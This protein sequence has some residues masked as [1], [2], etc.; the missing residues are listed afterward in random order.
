M[1]EAFAKFRVGAR[2][3][4]AAHASYIT[5]TSALDP[6]S[7]RYRSG[8][9]EL[10]D[11]EI[12]AAAAIDQDLNDGLDSAGPR[13][14]IDPVW[15]W[16]APSHLTGDHFGIEEERSSDLLKRLAQDDLTNHQQITAGVTS[17][18]SHRRLADKVS[19]LRAYFGSK[20]RFEKLK[21]GRTHYRVILSF[22][23][24]ATNSQIRDLTNQFLKDTF[25][26]A[27]AFGAIHRDTEHPHVHLYVHARQIDG[28]KIYL[29]KNEY[30][31][32][33]EN[34][35]RIYSEFAGDRSVFIQHL[36]KKEE[37]KQWKVAAAEAY[38]KGEL[39]PPKPERDSDRRER[40][41]EQK[42]SAQRSHARDQ[43]QQLKPRPEAKPVMRP[44][45]E[46]ETSRLLAKE[47]VARAELAHLIRIDTPASQI[48]WAA[49]SAHQFSVA[50][51][52]TLEARKAIGKQRFPQTVYTKDEWKQLKE[53]AA[54]R[55]LAV[56]DDP[57]AA[58]LQ[59]TRILAGAEMRDAQAR[60]DAFETRRHF[61][62]FPVEGL[63]K[64]SLR[65]VE[66]KIKAHTDDKFRLYNFLRP[67]KR[68]SIQL[69]IEFLQE[70]KKDIQKQ[71]AEAER[72]ARGNLASA[73][74]TFETVTT[75]VE[76][77]EKARAEQQNGMP[78]P[79]FEKAELSRMLQIATRNTDAK[80]LAF[81]YDEVK[82]DLL[83]NPTTA[84]L[85]AV[86]GRA[87][88][89]RM[90][91]LKAA[92]RLKAAVEYGDFRTMPIND[93]RGLTYTKSIR[94][95]APKGAL[96]TLIRHFTDSPEKKREQQALADARLDQLKQAGRQS[97]DARDYCVIR[98]RIAQDFY[99]AAGVHENSVVPR[100]GRDQIA[101]LNKYAD[102][103][104]FFSTDRKEF[105][106]AIRS[107]EKSV[108]E[109]QDGHTRMEA[110]P[111]A[112][113]LRG[114][115]AD[116]PTRQMRSHIDRSDPDKSSRGR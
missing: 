8:Q 12:S 15:T 42:L 50:L 5:R 13:D 115:G 108:L 105:K 91:M 75:L 98:E 82:H 19:K 25:P 22:D 74:L 17:R 116:E 80:L 73:R 49:M 45:S 20:E 27:I 61:W 81:V 41:A 86:K 97:R 65:E 34:W 99:K 103:L 48:K 77:A 70:V 30:L 102:T 69:K 111:P 113:H 101:E 26:K 71:I 63:G 66:Q 92:D 51:E 110:T 4:G 67:T 43:Q 31:S 100:L 35:A 57:A 88:M 93:A 21:G 29:A 59:S 109:T 28:R 85:S 24:P 11:A 55:D 104:S 56:R 96:E 40:L 18:N 64:L 112:Q 76:K 39:V 107:A 62:K 58:R 106:E 3:A 53:Y 2:G 87:V 33:D 10:A 114:G 54:T 46:K 72:P 36:R 94:D 84:T 37:T 95:A 52:K 16:N 68:E 90:E 9:L 78:K 44:G 23:V 14:D 47:E 79:V 7:W 83:A 6:D 38:R 89:A 32:I 60:V 1:A